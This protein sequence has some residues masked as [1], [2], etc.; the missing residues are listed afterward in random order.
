MMDRA[1]REEQGNFKDRNEASGEGLREKEKVGDGLHPN[2][3]G[4]D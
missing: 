3:L 4:R 2:H 1:R